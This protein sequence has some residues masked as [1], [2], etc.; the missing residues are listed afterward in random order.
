MIKISIRGIT[1]QHPIT[2]NKE[3]SSQCLFQ[4]YREWEILH[5]KYKMEIFTSYLNKK[6]RNGTS[7][8]RS[9]RYF[10]ERLIHRTIIT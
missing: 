5:T 6:Y 2:M 3:F 8:S 10:L 4:P 9:R 7:T 1:N